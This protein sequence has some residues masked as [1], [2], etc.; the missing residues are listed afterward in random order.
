LDCVNII[1]DVDRCVLSSLHCMSF[2]EVVLKQFAAC[3]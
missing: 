1:F 3:R 2:K